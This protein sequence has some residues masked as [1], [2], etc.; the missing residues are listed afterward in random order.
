MLGQRTG[1][2]AFEEDQ[3]LC[4][5]YGVLRL[6]LGRSISVQL[7]CDVPFPEVRRGGVIWVPEQ[8]YRGGVER[9]LVLLFLVGNS[10]L[11]M[12]MGV[13]EESSVGDQE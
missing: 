11:A 4:S 9:R 3:F 8:D 13:G 10:F 7:L 6:L 2:E 12:L 1:Q 5:Y